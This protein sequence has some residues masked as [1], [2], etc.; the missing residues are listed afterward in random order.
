MLLS[1]FRENLKMI[2]AFNDLA[3]G[4]RDQGQEVHNYRIV[5]PIIVA[6]GTFKDA[7]RVIDYDGDV[8]AGLISEG[9]TAAWLAF[10]KA[11]P[12]KSRLPG[13]AQF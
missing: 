1:S 4:E 6:P 5:K 13:D 3:K 10:E 11:F 2:E 12:K 7:Q 8:S 9:Y